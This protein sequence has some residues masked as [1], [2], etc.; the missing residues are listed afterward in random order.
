MAESPAPSMLGKR[1]W[2]SS[3]M[4]LEGLASE[5][6]IKPSVM[7]PATPIIK[8]RRLT[9]ALTERIAQS[10]VLNK[11]FV[12]CAAPPHLSVKPSFL[13]GSLT[14]ILESPRAP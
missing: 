13:F 3:G 4:H 1:S 8:S 9:V 6:S 5:M 14:S 2:Q 10:P 11:A 7:P 12:S